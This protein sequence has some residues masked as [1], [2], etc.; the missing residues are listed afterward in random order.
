VID[1][2]LTMSPY[3]DAVYGALGFVSG[4]CVALAMTSPSARWRT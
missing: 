2:L 4:V 3:A 1:L